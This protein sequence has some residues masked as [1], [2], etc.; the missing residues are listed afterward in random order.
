MMMVVVVMV[1][2]M[3]IMVWFFPVA[4]HK[5][6]QQHKAV[7]VLEQLTHNAVVEN[8]LDE[9]Y[10]NFMIKNEQLHSLR[11]SHTTCA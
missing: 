2:T 3:V 7:E 1:T 4:F 11:G 8:R 5:A 6:G 9:F 10:N